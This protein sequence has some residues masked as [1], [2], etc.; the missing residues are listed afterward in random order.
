MGMWT[1]RGVLGLE[2][3]RSPHISPDKWTPNL[4][5]KTSGDEALTTPGDKVV[6]LLPSFHGQ[7]EVEIL[8]LPLK[9]SE[10]YLMMCRAL[11]HE[12]K[13]GHQVSPK[14]D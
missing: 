10:V 3:V 5:L 1:G 9:A 13:C 4:S 6:L 8:P 14:L 2:G 7:S 12:R 11:P